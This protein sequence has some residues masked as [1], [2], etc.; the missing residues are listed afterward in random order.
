MAYLPRLVEAAT[1]RSLDIAEGL[2]VLGRGGP[3]GVGGWRG[4]HHEE[5]LP[6]APLIQELKGPVQ[7]EHRNTGTAVH[8]MF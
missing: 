3:G 8:I 4:Q 1:A 5:R 2:L 7:L 6:G